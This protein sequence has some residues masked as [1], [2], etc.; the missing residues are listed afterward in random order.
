M[1]KKKQSELSEFALAI[2]RLYE[3]PDGKYVINELQK[4]YVA[5]NRMPDQILDGGGV[6]CLLSFYEGQKKVALTFMD[7]I[8]Y[9]TGEEKNDN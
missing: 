2:R 9:K 8:N 3:T 7:C 1:T 4:R 6:G 5:V